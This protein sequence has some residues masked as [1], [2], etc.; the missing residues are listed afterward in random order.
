MSV[1]VKA[2][3]WVAAAQPVLLGFGAV[4][5]ALNL[6]DVLDDIKPIESFRN[7]LPSG[8]PSGKPKNSD[9]KKKYKTNKELVE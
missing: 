6:D 7:L 4:L 8:I 9:K 3:W 1:L 2:T 5:T